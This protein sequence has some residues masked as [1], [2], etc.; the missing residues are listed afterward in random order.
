MKVS[1]VVPTYNGQSKIMELL[2][3]LERQTFQNFETIVVI[4]G[5][6]DNTTNSLK[7]KVWQLQELRILEQENQGRAGARNMGAKLANG[8]LLIFFDDDLIIPRETIAWYLKAFATDA[9]AIHGCRFD[10]FRG[11]ASE[12][13][14]QFCKYLNSKWNQNISLIQGLESK[15]KIYLNAASF[16][17]S[18][19]IFLD[20]GGFD[21]NLRDNEDREFGERLVA[22]GHKIAIDQNMV[23]FHKIHG[24]FTAYVNRLREYEAARKAL[25]ISQRESNVRKALGRLLTNPLILRLIENGFFLWLPDRLR[26]KF[27]DFVVTTFSKDF[28]HRPLS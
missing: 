26:F 4:D 9:S 17:I 16:C 18:K 21:D 7:S 8:E 24:S 12:D 19:T 1:V 23:A 20:S 15:G 3:C 28:S 11:D 14:F 6:T 25:E 27:Y 5:S 10:P 13:F 2:G 22:K